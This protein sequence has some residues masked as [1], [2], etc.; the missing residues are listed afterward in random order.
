MDQC[1]II[2]EKKMKKDEIHFGDWSRILIGDV[3]AS[4]F[5]EALIRVVILYL[6]LIVSMRLMGKRISSGLTRN[7][8]VAIVSLAAAIGVPLQSPDR[9][10]FPAFIIAL[11]VIIIERLTA[12]WSSKS[13]KFEQYSQGHISELV[14]QGTMQIEN[15][16][17]ARISRERVISQLRSKSIRNLGMVKRFFLEA[18]GSF[19]VIKEEE[20]LAGLCLI[21]EW[22]ENYLKNKVKFA[23][24]SVCFNCGKLKENKNEENCVNCGQSHWVKAIH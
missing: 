13:E 14:K 7:E 19:T 6:L 9:G 23:E 11:V 20:P 17:K 10:I 3:P 15:M 1:N 24:E 4:F 5:I 18:G 2:K 16:K 12:K 8:M 22:D 21:P